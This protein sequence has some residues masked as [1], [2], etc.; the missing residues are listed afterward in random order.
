VQKSL[1]KRVLAGKD[2]FGIGAFG[3]QGKVFIAVTRDGVHMDLADSENGMEFS[4]LRAKLVIEKET[5][6]PG[7]VIT[8]GSIESLVAIGGG[9][10]RR[11]VLDTE[12]GVSAS[13]MVMGD[14]TSAVEVAPQKYWFTDKRGVVELTQGRNK[15]KQKVVI[16]IHEY[17]LG[18]EDLRVHLVSGEERKL[19]V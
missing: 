9:S 18:G 5:L 4:L 16:G 10:L 15:T 3:D 13:G 7:M 8:G 11:I 17:Y 2:F 14:W 1:G 19:V 6:N 12:H